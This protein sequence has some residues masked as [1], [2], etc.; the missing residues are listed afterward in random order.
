MSPL[1]DRGRQVW[2]GGNGGGG[3]SYGEL[4]FIV[5]GGG[6]SWYGIIHFLELRESPLAQQLF[7]VFR[8]QVLS[9]GHLNLCRN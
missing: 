7:F 3:G 4:Y 5:E 9:F 6:L 8:S 1:G 2:E